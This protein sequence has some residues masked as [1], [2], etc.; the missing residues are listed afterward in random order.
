M[1]RVLYKERVATVDLSGTDFASWAEAGRFPASVLST[2]KTVLLRVATTSATGGTNVQV[3]CKPAWDPVEAAVG[4]EMQ[5]YEAN[6]S[7]L[8]SNGI[9]TV[10]APTITKIL[11]VIFG[12]NIQQQYSTYPPY[13]V[14]EVLED[15][16]AGTLDIDAVVT[17]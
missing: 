17:G 15:R 5:M 4:E 6:D 10:A 7:A 12:A 1:S 11:A 3:R 14:V 2:A 13:I 8:L 9:L 16:T